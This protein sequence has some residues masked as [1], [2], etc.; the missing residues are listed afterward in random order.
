[1]AGKR[2]PTKRESQHTT[3]SKRG[4]K[5]KGKRPKLGRPRDGGDCSSGDGDRTTPSP[6][7]GPGGISCISFYL[8]YAAGVKTSG[9]QIF[10]KRAVSSI[11]G[12][13]EGVLVRM[14]NTVTVAYINRQGG[15][16]SC[17]MCRNS[18]AIQDAPFEP[19]QSA[20]LKLLSMKTLLLVALASMK[21]VGNLQAFLR[22]TARL[23]CSRVKNLLSPPP[24]SEPDMAGR[25]A[26][27]LYL[28]NH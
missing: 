9:T 25:P 17:R 28:L 22:P 27:G 15:L 26:P 21:R 16:R 2:P 13:E 6:R 23:Y 4:S 14:D 24:P 7:K 8:C 19:L 1:M 12:S 11:S 18:P 5:A 20:D 3:G 10:N